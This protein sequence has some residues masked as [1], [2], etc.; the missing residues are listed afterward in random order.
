MQ[1]KLQYGSLNNNDDEDDEDDN[2]DSWSF[3]N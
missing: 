1:L 3:D 2:D